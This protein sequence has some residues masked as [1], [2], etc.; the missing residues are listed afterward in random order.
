MHD[1]RRTVGSPSKA[2]R[3]RKDVLRWVPDSGAAEVLDAYTTLPWSAQ[4]EDAP[5]LNLS[6]QA[7]AEVVAVRLAARQPRARR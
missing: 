7:P 4:C 5:A 3:A 2:D 6:V 1:T